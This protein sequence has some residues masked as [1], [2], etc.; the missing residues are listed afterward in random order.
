MSFDDLAILYACINTSTWYIP[1]LQCQ[2]IKNE[3]EQGCRT[4]P[5]GYI[6]W[7][8]RFLGI[9]SRLIKSSKISSL[10]NTFTCTVSVT[11]VPL[12]GLGTKQAQGCRTGTPAF[13]A[14]LL[15]S[16]LGSWNRFLAPQRD[17][18]FRLCILPYIHPYRSSERRG[19][20][21]K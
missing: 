18:S 7:R 17:L 5:P 9:D 6:G 10:Y 16:T 15:N 13:V 20:P 8:N 1:F 12:W 14:W 19:I 2:N 11:L 4:G 21:N 3:Q